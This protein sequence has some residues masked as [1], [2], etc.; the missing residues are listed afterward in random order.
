LWKKSEKNIYIQSHNIWSTTQT[1]SQYLEQTKTES[2]YLEH[3]SSK[4]TVF[5][6]QLKQNHN[7]GNKTKTKSQ[8]LEHNSSKIIIFG[9]QLK[10]KS[11]Y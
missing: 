2:Q 3:H 4:I 6:T 7:I 10:A 11:Q 8:Y 5:G 9:T 1:K